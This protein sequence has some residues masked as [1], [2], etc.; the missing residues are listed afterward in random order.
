M[1]RKTF[2]ALIAV[3]GGSFAHAAD[4][5]DALA[6]PLPAIELPRST[7]QKKPSIPVLGRPTQ[8]EIGRSQNVVSVSNGVNEIVYVSSTMPNRI[9]TPFANPKVVDRDDDELSYKTVGQDVYFTPTQG[10]S[11]GIFIYD[12]DRPNGR[13]ATLTL[14]PQP[15]PGQNII[16][17]FDGSAPAVAR[18]E[19]E[20]VNQPSDYVDGL[21]AVMRSI[22]QGAAPAGYTEG[23]LDVGTI[24][25]GSLSVIPDRQY[26]GR[27][28]NVYRYRIEN[29]SRSTVDLSEQAFYENGVRAVAFWPNIRLEPGA[30]T[31]VLIAVDQAT[32]EAR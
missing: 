23:R 24:M 27:Y 21:R 6:T 32:E 11:I 29:V 13:V 9:A 19:A 10:G 31:H 3:L 28:L 25:V 15:I 18:A 16:L 2:L 26:I 4:P 20:T 30:T 14:V 22:A 7:L 1:M 5:R 8:K 17:Q 12:A